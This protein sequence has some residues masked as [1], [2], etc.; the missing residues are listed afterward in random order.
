MKLTLDTGF[1]IVEARKNTSIVVVHI[2]YMY[3]FRFGH[4]LAIFYKKEYSAFRE[5]MLISS[6]CYYCGKIVEQKG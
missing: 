1:F 5:K 2:K 6:D 4:K 3:P